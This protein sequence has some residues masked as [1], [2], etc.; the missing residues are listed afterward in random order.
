MALNPQQAYA[1]STKKGPVLILAGAGTGKTRVITER[2]LSLLKSGVFGRSIVGVTFTNKAAR[3]MKERILALGKGIS[4]AKDVHISTFHSF[5]IFLLRKFGNKVGLSKTFAI[6]PSYDQ[7]SVVRTVLDEL[8]QSG[9]Y[10]A[11]FILELISKCKNQLVCPE[12][13]A[14][15]LSSLALKGVPSNIETIYDMYNR[16]LLVNN[17]IDF[18]DCIFK[19]VELLRGDQD[20]KTWVHE[21]YKYWMVDEFQDTNFAQFYL[22]K[23]LSEDQRN[24]CV[25]GDDDQSIY[26]WRGAEN[27][28]LG[29]FEEE[30]PERVLI[31]LEQNYRS[32]NKILDVA[33]VVIE[34]NTNRLGKVLFSESRSS[35][36]V[37]IVSCENENHEAEWVADYIS[38][39]IGHEK[40][41]KN[42]SILFRTNSQAKYFEEVFKERGFPYK[43]YGGT[44]FF[45]KKEI[46]D[47]IAYYK[48]IANTYDNFSFW[49]IVNSPSRG[50]GLKYREEI[51]NLGK[52]LNMSAF[53]AFG[54]WLRRNA[55][56][57]SLRLA[58]E[59][60]TE[61]LH[62]SQKEVLTENDVNELGMHVL[63][64]FDLTEDITSSVKDRAKIAMRKEN[65]KA[66]PRW[67]GGV[68][69]KQTRFDN[70]AHFQ[71]FLNE[72]LSESFDYSNKE[73]ENA[74]HL[75]TIHAAK[76]LEFP[77]VFVCGLEEEFLP[78]KNSE[79]FEQI[80]EERR[81][82]YVAIT[83]AREE[84]I[85]SYTLER[86]LSRN[87]ISRKKSRF[88]NEIPESYIEAINTFPQIDKKEKTLNKL[89]SIKEMLK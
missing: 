76:G 39:N 34:K 84:L 8:G 42:F 65:L 73:D 62:L 25:V 45:E 54:L 36:L 72:F 41:Y 58:K 47:L 14:K 5:C 37:N 32:T 60:Y 80:N 88:I 21:R 63:D 48:L 77:T 46:K 17:A 26:S 30:Y 49:R 78:H 57:E 4:G 70:E 28:I 18:D 1:V 33:N 2:I 7:I 86:K 56:K 23:L 38:K 89:A 81:L 13:A 15:F 35:K 85:L 51:S 19:S 61:I 27:K 74:I 16:E 66:V 44:S 71:R 43:V 50:I 29:L 31:K 6:L 69:A 20:A 3:E 59:F 24:I 67:L 55:G 64:K 53:S 75:M 82:F 83:R 22:I 12:G 10:D 79:H 9:L 52:E 11:Y 40:A 87:R 68:F